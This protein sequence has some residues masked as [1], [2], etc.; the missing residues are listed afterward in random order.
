MEIAGRSFLDGGAVSSVSADL[1]A[2]QPL[3]EVV[4]V[5]PMTSAGGAPGRD[6]A[7]IERLLRAQMTAGLDR[8]VAIL[9]AA[10]I[11]VI[12]VEPGPEELDAMGPNFMDLSRR[13]ATLAAARAHAADRVAA[14]LEGAHA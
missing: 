8:E 13:D 2:G 7:R 11:R 12:R 14:A 6:S 3:D 5:A 1:L 9:E 4:V 10:G